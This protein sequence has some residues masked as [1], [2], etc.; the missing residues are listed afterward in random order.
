M[1][2][3]HIFRSQAVVDIYSSKNDP[4]TAE[5]EFLERNISRIE[6][7]NVLIQKLDMFNGS[8]T[9]ELIAINH[10]LNAITGMSG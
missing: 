2:N 7:Y 8:R 5:L 1:I 9:N 10:K 4:T 6:Q 3:N